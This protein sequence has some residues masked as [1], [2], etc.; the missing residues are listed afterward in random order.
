M[1]NDPDYRENQKRA[2]R[3]WQA[4]NPGY[5]SERRKTN[6]NDGDASRQQHDDV[7][8]TSPA[9]IELPAGLYRIQPAHPSPFAKMD[10][11]IVRIAPVCPDC[12][13]KMDAC[14]ERT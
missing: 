5:W 14:K 2:Q 1:Q 8:K 6:F 9:V 12:P 7:Q 10:A 3:A 13:C 11:W 4:R